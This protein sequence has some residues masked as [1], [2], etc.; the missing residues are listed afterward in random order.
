MRLPRV[1]TPAVVCRVQ[2]VAFGAD[3]SGMIHQRDGSRNDLGAAI[4]R[5]D[6]KRRPKLWDAGLLR[7]AGEARNPLPPETPRVPP[8]G[9]TR[10]L[11]E[12]LRTRGRRVSVDEAAK[13]LKTTAVRVRGLIDTLRN[14]YHWWIVNGDRLHF[15]L[16]RDGWPA[17]WGRAA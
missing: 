6:G 16:Q 4:R 8:P 12:L 14:R 7:G 3:N 17:T 13:H 10:D 2:P 15:E 11:L 1:L 9:P 5:R